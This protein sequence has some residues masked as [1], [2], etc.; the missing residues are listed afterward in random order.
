MQVEK[1]TRDTKN[2]GARYTHSLDDVEVQT[3]P[4][5]THVNIM[6]I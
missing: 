5:N 1:W 6:F 2:K 3:Y 4:N